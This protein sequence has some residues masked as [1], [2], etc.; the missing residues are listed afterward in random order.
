MQTFLHERLQTLQRLLARSSEVLA[1]YNRLDLDLAVALT[2]F[3]DEA[4]AGS[5]ALGRA[6][7]ENQLLALQ[8]QFVSAQQGTHPMTLERAVGHR[9]ELQRSVALH[10]LQRSAELL[11]ADIVLDGQALDA[12]RALLRPIVLAAIQQGLVDTQAGT[13]PGQPELE[14]L[15][16]RLL[17]SPDLHLAARQLAMQLG[18]YD[19]QLLLA[20]LIQAASDPA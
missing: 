17:K 4:I 14:A 5:H 13:P 20:E 1:K 16:S 7:L 3:V 6:Q 11:R 12:G 2:D 10:V 19:I 18:V 8:A 9:R 15:W